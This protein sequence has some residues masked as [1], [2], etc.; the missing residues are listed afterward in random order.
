MRFQAAVIACVVGLAV[1]PAL[2]AEE[3]A[4][5]PIA[6]QPYGWQ[7]MTPEERAAHCNAMRAA[8]T[9]EQREQLRAAHHAQMVER[10]RERGITLPDQPPQGRGPGA[11]CRG[12]GAGMGMGP[13]GGR[14]PRGGMG[15][16]AGMGP[17]GGTGPGPA[18]PPP[19][20]P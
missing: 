17:G 11:G 2:A 13:G 10:A 20:Q 19:P 3:T 18:A 8:Q 6:D 16:G 1:A 15:P 7:L 5:A 4:P 14:G 12:M 9:P